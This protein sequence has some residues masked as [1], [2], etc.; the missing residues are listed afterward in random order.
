[1][2]ALISPRIKEQQG[3]IKVPDTDAPLSNGLHTRR[4]APCPFLA[5]IK[6]QT[7]LIQFD[8]KRASS[9]KR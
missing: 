8:F 7:G 3:N 5:G 6:P 1:M 4:A 2:L 9:F